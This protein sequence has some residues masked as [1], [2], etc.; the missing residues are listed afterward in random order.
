M[1][2]TEEVTLPSKGLVYPKDNPL[3]KGVIEMKYMTAKEEDILT[4]ESYLKKGI[5]VDKLLQSLIVTQIN[6]DDL[7]DGDKNAIL[8]AARVLGY[9]KDYKFKYP[10][11]KKE[12]EEFTI[13]LTEVED[14]VLDE[15]H[16]IEPYKNEF[17]FVLPTV[18]K[19]ITFKFLDSSDEKKIE[20]E[21]NG[22]KRID[23]KGSHEVTTR[24]KYMI[25]S[26]DGNYDR[27]EVREF[28]DSGYLLA[29]DIKEWREYIKEIQPN[30][31]LIFDL[32]DSYGE[33]L[34]GVNVP[35]GVTF[36]WPFS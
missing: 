5:A 28:V 35:I 25:Q 31:D 26:I 32:E 22:L 36:L 19:E 9:G 12:E 7:I 13:D 30:V 17:K 10:N 20:A 16:L 4:N 11:S 29:R 2:P 27:K 14:K 23:K 6:Y 21:L 33:T 34:R 1:Y 18:K 24:L 3:S 15:K 8:I